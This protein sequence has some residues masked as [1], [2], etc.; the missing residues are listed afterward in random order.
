[1]ENFLSHGVTL[2]T[3]EARPLELFKLFKMYRNTATT[4]SKNSNAQICMFLI[5][6]SG[7][8][9][10]FCGNNSSSFYYIKETI[11]VCD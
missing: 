5:Y 2:V 10:S 6:S 9:A 7:K 3:D 11:L 4:A 8:D 1:M